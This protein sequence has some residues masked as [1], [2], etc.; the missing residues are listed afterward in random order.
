[1][2]DTESTKEHPKTMQ[3]TYIQLSVSNTVTQH[4]EYFDPV[5]CLA[6]DLVGLF[7]VGRFSLERPE[8]VCLTLRFSL[9]LHQHFHV[10]L[11]TRHTG[12]L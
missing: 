1:M 7:L 2:L 12:L 3:L 8:A 10:I 4:V 9:F 5:L 11:K 6:G